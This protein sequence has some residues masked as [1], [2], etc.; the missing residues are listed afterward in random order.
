MIQLS[1]LEIEILKSINYGGGFTHKYCSLSREFDCSA[2]IL[3]DSIHFH[4]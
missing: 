4:Q 2:V 1:S 3:G